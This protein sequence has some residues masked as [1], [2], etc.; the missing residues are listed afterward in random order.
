[1]SGVDELSSLS[2]TAES[3]GQKTRRN[4]V[5]N[6]EKRGSIDETPVRKDMPSV[7]WVTQ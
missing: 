7:L 5:G 1:L 2:A 3:G 6:P 4:V